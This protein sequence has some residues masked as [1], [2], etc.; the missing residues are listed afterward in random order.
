MRLLDFLNGFIDI[1]RSRYVRYLEAEVVR[2]R[3]ETAGLNHTLL[4]SKGIQQVPTP[5]LQALS[6]RGRDL[7]ATG[8]TGREAGQ[9]RPVVSSNTHAKLRMQLE[10]QSQKEA[11]QMEQEIRENREKREE[12]KAH[13]QK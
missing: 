3:M 12:V 13:A 7:R 8:T 10:R 2:L 9:M 4:S 11:A 1:F 5:D 6:A